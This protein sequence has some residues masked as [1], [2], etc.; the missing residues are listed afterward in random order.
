MSATKGE[1]YVIGTKI[2]FCVMPNPI[3]PPPLKPSNGSK[4]KPRAPIA[5]PTVSI[6]QKT[7]YF[8]NVGYDLTLELLDE[9]ENV[10]YSVFVPLQT[11]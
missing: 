1:E 8:Y 10:V 2:V 4:P 9:E 11:D 5:K 7:L 3:D 6:D